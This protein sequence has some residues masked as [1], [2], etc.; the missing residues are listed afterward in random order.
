MPQPAEFTLDDLQERVQRALRNWHR[1]TRSP[2]PLAHLHLFAQLYPA[3]ITS[4]HVATNQVLYQALQLLA[5]RQPQ[6]ADV[7]QRTV[8]DRQLNTRVAIETN[9][10]ESTL[11]RYKKTAVE[12]LTE[13]LWEL[14][15][16][17]R[18]AS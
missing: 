2:S 14:E 13:C 3:H 10:A 1:D 11:F 6:E 4:A 18:E 16:Q 8:L 7:L 15:Q 17:S 9:V 5:E 12:H